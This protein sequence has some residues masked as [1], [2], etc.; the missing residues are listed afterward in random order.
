MKNI[1]KSILFIA[2]AILVLVQ[3]A[4]KKNFD[5]YATNP[6]QLTDSLYSIDYKN[7]GGYLPQMQTTVFP[8]DVNSY[9]VGQN[10]NA[11]I[12]SGYMG[13]Q[14]AFN[15]GL[16]N[17]NYAL[18][19]SWNHEP[20]N[21]GYNVFAS[22]A[23]IKQRASNYPDFIAVATIIKVE[24]L[25]RVTDV[26]GP[27]PYSK[28]GTVAFGTPY[29]A[30]QSV[31]NAFFVDLDG[32]IK[33]LQD[34]SATADAVTKTRLRQFDLVFGG[35]IS[36][37]IKFANSLKLRLAMRLVYVDAALAQ[38]KAEEA[39]AA[40]VM[41]DNA[42]NAMVKSANG[43]TVNNPIP[44][45]VK[46]YDDIRMGASAES[47]LK[48]YNDPRLASYYIPSTTTGTPYRGIRNG[49]EDDTKRPSYSAFSQLNI[50]ASTPIQW[51]VA[52]EM[53]FLRAEGALRGWNMNGTAQSLYETGIATSFAQRNVGSANAYI[54]NS[55]SLPA[56]YADPV[57]PAQS[58]TA[59]STITIKWNAG[60][61]FE[62]NLER[63]I[64][65]KWISIFPDGQEAWTEFR[66]TGYP[67]IFPV[68]NNRSGGLIPGFIR[69][70]PFTD[71]EYSTNAAEVQK[72]ISLLG[73][74]D[75]GGTKL[76]WDKK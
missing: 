15:S 51:M 1:N 57:T 53:F 49:N 61:S 9:Q 54:S 17:A 28:V 10:L 26:Y 14:H 60:D 13:T 40:G 46:D 41:T 6:K 32:A 42:D 23:A 7:I 37:W 47:I 71:Q 43:V 4:C 66:R 30:Q 24:S 69:R 39:V 55:T 34:F 67:K 8:T 62:R 22:W 73:G 48:G 18:V 76:W 35:D 2:V 29:D 68:L 70:L 63:I 65:Q 50:Q 33:S 27:I 45:I 64:T 19:P 20:F 52:A 74:P 12:F 72:A 44:V 25:H 16:N 75:N 59:Q 58:I 21:I 36:K 31:Y 56:A 11:D 5:L 3:S 38:K